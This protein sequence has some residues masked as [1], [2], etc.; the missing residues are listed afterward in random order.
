MEHK[1]GDKKWMKNNLPVSS[2]NKDRNI[3]TNANISI[4][5]HKDF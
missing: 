3:P 1:I 5:V 4:A 2:P